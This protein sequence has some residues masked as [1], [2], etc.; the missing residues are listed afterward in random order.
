MSNNIL[1]VVL[2]Y[3]YTCPKIFSYLSVTFTFLITASYYDIRVGNTSADLIGKH[4]TARRIMQSE[5][6]VGNLS[7]PSP[8]Y[9]RETFT[10]RVSVNPM[11]NSSYVFMVRAVD[12]AGNKGGVSNMVTAGLG[13]VPDVTVVL[14]PG[15]ISLTTT[16]QKETSVFQTL[17]PKRSSSAS[18][19]STLMKST[20][21]PTVS[22]TT[23]TKTPPTATTITTTLQSKVASNDK[24]FGLDKPTALGAIIGGT[25]GVVVLVVVSAVVAVLMKK[26]SNAPPGVK[27]KRFGS[28]RSRSITPILTNSTEMAEQR[29]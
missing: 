20:P 26:K 21:K 19:T 9:A 15:T 5:V 27:G 25:I 1:C 4:D 17:T 12:E 16:S 28:P 2:Q 13:F 3:K 18:P 23:K 7:S 14:L 11:E 24:L 29:V 6:I 8:A 22:N 10:I